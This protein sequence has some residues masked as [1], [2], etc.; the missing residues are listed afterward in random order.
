MSVP[1][2]KILVLEDD[3]TSGPY[4]AEGL[5]EEGHSV[6]LMANGADGRGSNTFSLSSLHWYFLRPVAT[7]FIICWR[8]CR[9][10][11]SWPR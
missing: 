3:K 9:F 5:R 10:R 8:M 1:P 11:K 6:D 4:I 2:L 7:R